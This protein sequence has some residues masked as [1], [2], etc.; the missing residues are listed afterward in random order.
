MINAGFL[1]TYELDEW[2]QR[3]EDRAY[4]DI[5]NNDDVELDDDNSDDNDDHDLKVT[6][7]PEQF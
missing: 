7:Y 3:M 1:N 4:D 5:A 6:Y 2:Y